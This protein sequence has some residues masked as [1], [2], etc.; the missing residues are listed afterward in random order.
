MLPAKRQPS[1]PPWG[2]A[3]CQACISGARQYVTRS[4]ERGEI[5]RLE[6]LQAPAGVRL[7]TPSLAEALISI[8]KDSRA[9]TSLAARQLLKKRG[10]I[11][12]RRRVGSVRAGW[13]LTASGEWTLKE[14]LL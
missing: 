2:E 1:L 10:L 13:V 11:L 7:L 3:Y 6:W 14:M 9:L 12:H 4:P 8:S 5:D